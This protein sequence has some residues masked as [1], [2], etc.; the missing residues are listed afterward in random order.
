MLEFAHHDGSA[1]Y[2][3]SDRPSIGSLVSVSIVVPS[4]ANAPKVWVR[5]TRDG[6]PVYIEATIDKTGEH[7][8]WWRAEITVTNFITNYRFLLSEPNRFVNQLGTFAHEVP[9]HHDFK[10]VA[11]TAPPQWSQDAIMY[12]VFPDRFA[13]SDHADTRALPEWAIPRTWNEAPALDGEMAMKEVFGGDLDG[14]ASKAEHLKSL[15]IDLVYSTPVFPA[16]SNHRYDAT[17]FDHIDPL[18]G[19]DEAMI[20]CVETLHNNGIRF[21]G[22]LTTNHTGNN[23]EWFVNAQTDQDS[24][25][26]SF[27][28]FHKYPDDYECWFGFRSLPKLDFSSQVLMRRLV[29]GQHSVVAK[30]LQPPYCFDG[31]RIDVANM[32]GRTG[33]DDHLQQVASV[34]RETL[35]S[36]NP[37]AFVVAEHAH[38]ATR[39][40]T[41][42]GWYSTMNYAGFTNPVWAWLGKASSDAQFFGMPVARP[43]YDGITTRTVIDS[44]AAGVSWRTRSHNMSL[45]TSHDS[46]RFRSVVGG[47]IDRHIV[48]LGVMIAMP[49]IP[50]VFQGDELGMQA[51]HNHITRSPLPWDR[52]ELWDQKLLRAYKDLLG[53]RRNS[54]ALRRGGFR[55]VSVG[56]D[57]LCWLRETAHDRVLCLARRASGSALSIESRLLGVSEKSSSPSLTGARPL[58]G[59]RVALPGDGPAFHIWQLAE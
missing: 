5:V 30:Y 54:E 7:E 14:L 47:D 48:G 53:F 18:L 22:D 55:W 34:L 26:R 45:L 59:A 29:Q 37:E 12:H 23:H 3:S 25:E 19:G 35:E 32:T 8:T 15:H 10:L 9:D 42:D 28:R 39:D 58:G 31:W 6:E 40:L 24:V 38:D 33:V 13:R 43:I 17:S 44:F 56:V 20:R 57:H 11:Y 27:Y 36:T 21:I 2:V 1:R 16:R 4:I 51:D 52:P 41:G 49:G 50:S 46:M